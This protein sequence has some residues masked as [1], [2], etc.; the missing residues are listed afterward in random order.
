[1]PERSR[2][3][4]D[5]QAAGGRPG[6][7]RDD[8]SEGHPD[9]EAAGASRLFALARRDMERYFRHD[10]RTGAPG[11]LE[12]L[13]ILLGSPGLQSVLV[14]RLGSWIQ[15]TVRL[16]LLRYPL[17]A[18]YAVLHKLCIILWGIHID[19]RAQIGGGLYI[20]HFGGVLIGPARLG[21]DCSL[22]HQVTIGHRADGAPGAP[23]LGDRVWVG[24][25]SVIFGSLTIGDG[26]TIGPLTMVARNLPPRSMVLGNP[27]RVLRTDYDNSFEIYGTR[28]AAARSANPP[29]E[30][31]PPAPAED[32]EE[33]P[34]SKPA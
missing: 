7:D 24:T 11:F 29:D 3:E 2:D 19:V 22:A 1:M 20:G 12:K 21:R 31:C 9:V 33:S 17:K 32:R 25:G 28:T 18:L 4:R 14:Y 5:D 30:P 10:S 13:G 26:A 23:V 6:T 27:M 16:A 15:R 34:S 8:V